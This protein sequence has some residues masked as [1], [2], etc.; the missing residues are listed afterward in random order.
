M[1]ELHGEISPSGTECVEDVEWPHFASSL[2]GAG[3]ISEDEKHWSSRRGGWDL[4]IFKVT[5]NP[6]TSYDFQKLAVLPRSASCC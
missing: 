4:M 3:S 1:D 2:A 6:L 5:S